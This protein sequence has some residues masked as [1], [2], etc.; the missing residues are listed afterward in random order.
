MVLVAG[1]VA[2]GKPVTKTEFYDFALGK[3]VEGPEL[4]Q[5]K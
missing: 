2:D 1:G 4:K 3:F 5:G